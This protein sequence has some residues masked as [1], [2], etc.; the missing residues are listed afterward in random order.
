LIAGDL[1]DLGQ[2]YSISQANFERDILPKL[3]EYDSV[4][5]FDCKGDSAAGKTEETQQLH[6]MVE[7]LV[8]VPT[9]FIWC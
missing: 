4:I 3:R 2:L 1:S 8:I 7:K 6:A 5:W 9:V